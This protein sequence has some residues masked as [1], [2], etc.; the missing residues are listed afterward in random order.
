[1]NVQYSTHRTIVVG[2]YSGITLKHYLPVDVSQEDIDTAYN[3][4]AHLFN[5]V[6]EVTAGIIGV[7]AYDNFSVEGK[8]LHYGSQ[9]GTGL[10]LLPAHII[11]KALLL[12]V[13]RDLI[14][15]P[16]QYEA[17]SDLIH[18]LTETLATKHYNRLSTMCCKSKL[19][20]LEHAKTRRV[21]WELT[22]EDIT[23]LTS[24]M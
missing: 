4:I 15:I 23:V 21:V 5:V 24:T 9:S 12:K 8:E 2:A 11:D 20:L 7:C 14:Y 6:D 1:M 13:I 18:K 17:I 22:T 3:A 16:C 10:G 19:A